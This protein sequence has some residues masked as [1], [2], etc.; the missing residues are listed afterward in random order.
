MSA[1]LV[2]REAQAT[3]ARHGRTFRQAQLLLPRDRAEDAAVIYALCRL[4]DDL[5]DESPDEDA[6]RA[7][8]DRLLAEL[9]LEVEPS[10]VVARFLEVLARRGGDLYPAIALVET[11]RGDL[12]PARVAD[13]RALVRYAW[14][15]AGTVGLLMSPV[16]GARDPAARGPAEDLGVAMQITNIC[17]D[18]REDAERGRVYLPETRLRDAGLSPD[19]ILSLRADRGRLSRV[20]SELLDLADFYYARAR[21]G[22]RYLPLRPRLAVVVAGALY[23]RIGLR[24]RR[25]HGADPLVGRT[26]VPPLERLWVALGALLRQLTPGLRA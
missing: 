15:V 10:P 19:E 12:T 14:G 17:R 4:A 2:Q 11:L 25:V 8:L 16:L 24:L 9:R 20:V 26:V 23:R 1:D 7:G 21:E 13:D 3:L 6:A 18:V 5:A 22:Y